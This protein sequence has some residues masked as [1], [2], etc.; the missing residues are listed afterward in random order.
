MNVHWRKSTNESVGKPE[1]NFDAAFGRSFR[2]STVNIFKDSSRNI[3]FIFLWMRQ[4]KNV[5]QYAHVQKIL[6][7]FY[8]L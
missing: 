3:N 2:I 4:A 7:S 8:R 5:K 6:I 1:Q